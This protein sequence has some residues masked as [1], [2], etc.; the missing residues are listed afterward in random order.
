MVDLK[1]NLAS[2]ARVSYYRELHGDL[3]GAAA[4]MRLAVGAGGCRA[5][6]NVLT[7]L[8]GVEL[9]RGD[10]AAARNSY[11]GALARVPEYQPAHAGL[12]RAD[13]LQGDYYAAIRASSVVDRLP[14]PEYAIALGEAELASGDRARRRAVVR[15]R[16]R[17]ARAAAAR[18]INT[19]AEYAIF[20]ADHGDP[21]APSTRT[22]AYAAAPSVRSADAYGWA[23]TRAG[24]PDEGLNYAREALDSGQ[25]TPPSAPRADREARGDRDEA[26]SSS[27][28]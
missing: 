10:F 7:L 24:R 21:R 3:D 15:P 25:R 6:A 28:W 8:G 27:P 26:G 11:R 16:S 13:F 2:Y 22:V 23:L 9:Q 19:D 20:E 18:G 1:P 4:A 12:A 17:R 14:L 5:E